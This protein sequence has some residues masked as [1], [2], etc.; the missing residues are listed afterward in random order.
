MTHTLHRSGTRESLSGDFVFLFMPAFG[1]NNIDS[2]PKLR[3]FFEIA[4]RHNPVNIGNAF[5]GS[6]SL[7]GLQNVL[8]NVG[9]DGG[10]VHAVFSNEEDAFQM[11]QEV[12]EADLGLS[13][14]ISGIFD[15]VKELCQRAGIQRHA[16]T[17]SLGIWGRAEKLPPEEILDVITMCGHGMVSAN[18]VYAAIED[19]KASRKSAGDAAKDLCQQCDCGVFNP[20]RAARLLS[21][22]AEKH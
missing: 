6:M 18:R 4:L 21:A 12:K 2:G 20:V 22:M 13:L 19:V 10:C 16:V 14:V 11:L 8:D 7:M 17:Y 9:K 1:I 3:R 5:Y 15:K